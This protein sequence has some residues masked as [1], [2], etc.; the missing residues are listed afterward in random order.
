MD[1]FGGFIAEQIIR[2]VRDAAAKKSA[3]PAVEKAR[4]AAEAEAAR[5]RAARAPQSGAAPQPTVR[6]APNLPPAPGRA[7]AAPGRASAPPSTRPSVAP[8]AP[9]APA[10]RPNAASPDAVLLA[11]LPP[12]PLTLDD[13][14]PG[15]EPIEPL[16]AG[17]DFGSPPTPVRPAVRP[18]LLS[19]FTSGGS[20][21]AG[22]VLGEALAPPISLRPGGAHRE[23]R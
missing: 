2:A 18:G 13:G 11:P 22:I 5:R 20:L 17:F 14:L 23:E 10:I 9:P 3:S 4:I 16:S 21:I 6:R 12:A 7:A 1:E 15:L 19:A 8:L